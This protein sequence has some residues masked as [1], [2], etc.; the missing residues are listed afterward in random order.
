M[1]Q[2]LTEYQIFKGLVLG[3]KSLGFY[4]GAFFFTFLALLVSLWLH[5]RKR[6]PASPNT[7]TKFSWLFLIWD[8]LKRIAVGLI[9]MFL[10]YRFTPAMSMELAVGLGSILSIGL[11]K[12]IQL[13]KN[14]YNFLQMN[15]DNFPTKP[16][17]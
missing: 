9:V 10:F 1:L 8:N 14:K 3:E 17:T 6:D 13:L 16:Q 15:R 12:A 2:V 5:S 4:M 7:P 11:D